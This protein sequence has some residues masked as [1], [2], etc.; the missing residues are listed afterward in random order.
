MF[1]DND[2]D[3]ENDN[4]YRDSDLDFN[5]DW[6]RGLHLLQRLQWLQRQQFRFRLRAI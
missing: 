2:N 4:Y 6:E 5:L 1:V 3:N